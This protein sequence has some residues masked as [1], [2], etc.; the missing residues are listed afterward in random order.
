MFNKK[1]NVTMYDDSKVTE[2]SLE[3]WQQEPVNVNNIHKLTL[4]IL[5]PNGKYVLVNTC[6][7]LYVGLKGSGLIL[8][9]VTL[10]VENGPKMVK[11]SS[12]TALIAMGVLTINFFDV[13]EFIVVWVGINP[14]AYIA[15]ASEGD[16]DLQ[17]VVI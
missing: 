8:Q 9:R 10:N 15:I 4:N 6:P 13:G 14:G 11:D 12:I 3:Q 1:E 2:F 5:D 7:D 16:V 17:K